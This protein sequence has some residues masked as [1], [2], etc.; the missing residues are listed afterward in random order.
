MEIEFP[1]Y[2]NFFLRRK[3]TIFICEESFKE[4]IHNIFKETLTGCDNFEDFLD[5]FKEDYPNIPYI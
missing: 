3:K 4:K 1:I 2:F 5:D